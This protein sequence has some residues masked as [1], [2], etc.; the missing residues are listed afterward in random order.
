[1]NDITFVITSC[2]RMDLLD[3]T[4]ESFFEICNYKFDK[5][6]ITEDS[7][8]REHYHYINKKW[9][10]I[11]DEIIFHVGE[12]KGI[13]IID[14]AYELVDTEYIFHCENDWTFHLDKNRLG[15]IKDSIIILDK[16]LDINQ[17]WIRDHDDLTKH[18]P[19]SAYT[20]NFSGFDGKALTRSY[21]NIPYWGDWCGFS[22][23]PGL[24]RKADYDKIKPYAQFKKESWV[25]SELEISKAYKKLY[26]KAVWLGNYC[27]HI[28]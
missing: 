25:K 2:G 24:R 10:H 5:F 12:R 3:R 18:K 22:L 23:N 9:G 17:V 7:G 8:D 20:N 4:L 28:G 16:I 14:E 27:Y 15:F 1:M 19:E 6:I 26:Y 11:F 21:R 13:G